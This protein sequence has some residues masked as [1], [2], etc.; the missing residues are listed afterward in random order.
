MVNISILILFAVWNMVEIEVDG[1][2]NYLELSP[3]ANKYLNFCICWDF[4]GDFHFVSGFLYSN[5]VNYLRIEIEGDNPRYPPVIW[6]EN[7]YNP[8]INRWIA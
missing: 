7:H 8:P 3:F 4:C 1:F 2:I 5:M 6:G